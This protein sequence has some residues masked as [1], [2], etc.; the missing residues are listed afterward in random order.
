MEFFRNLSISGP[1]TFFASVSRINCIIFVW[2]FLH[3]ITCPKFPNVASPI[4]F[5]YILLAQMAKHLNYRNSCIA[6]N[7]YI[8]FDPFTSRDHRSDMRFPWP[9]H[10]PKAESYIP[11]GVN[12]GMGIGHTERKWAYFLFWSLSWKSIS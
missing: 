10:V 8:L 7:E 11:L 5:G 12:P 9:D 2:F 1:V 6:C 4:V 3:N